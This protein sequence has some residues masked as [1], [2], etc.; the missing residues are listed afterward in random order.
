MQLSFKQNLPQTDISVPKKNLEI[1]LN[2][3]FFFGIAFIFIVIFLGIIFNLDK[4]ESKEQK[5]KT[6]LENLK[7]KIRNS[8]NLE[9]KE[10]I[11]FCNLLWVIEG[12]AIDNCENLSVEQ[13]K[14][15]IT[16]R[17]IFPTNH[18]ILAK[19]LDIEID[20]FEDV[21]QNI[22]VK[23]FYESINLPNKF[24]KNILE[25]RNPDVGYWN[26][27]YLAFRPSKN[28]KVAKKFEL[29]FFVAFDS[30]QKKLNK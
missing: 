2:P 28:K 13:Y 23:N 18:Q 15:V 25:V 29:Y 26:R 27:D 5:N 21:K 4:Q 3:K 14:L 7:A 30:I 17:A 9:N 16:N 20:D 1:N 19:K 24:K 22:L 10:K 11:E 8:E 6:K 12:I